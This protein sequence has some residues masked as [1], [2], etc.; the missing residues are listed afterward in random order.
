MTKIDPGGIQVIRILET[1]QFSRLLVEKTLNF[2]HDC[3][4]GFLIPFGQDHS[5]IGLKRLLVAI[6]GNPLPQRL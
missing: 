6:E 1:V 3:S 4:D 2:E 5:S